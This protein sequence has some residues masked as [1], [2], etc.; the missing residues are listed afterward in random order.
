MPVIWKTATSL[1]L[2]KYRNNIRSRSSIKLE[3]L[4]SRSRFWILCNTRASELQTNMQVLPPNGIYEQ[5]TVYAMT[6][7]GVQESTRDL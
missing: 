5:M 6:E 7:R 4:L 1:N 3:R 2:V